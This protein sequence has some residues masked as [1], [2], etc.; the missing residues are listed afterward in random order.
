MLC[1]CL[2]SS[3]HLFRDFG[4]VN[5]YSWF[6]K[7]FNMLDRSGEFSFFRGIHVSIDVRIDISIS[8]RPMQVQAGTSRRLD[9]N[10]ANQA[11]AGDVIMSR[12]LDKLKT[13]YLHSQS[14]NCHETWQD[15]DLSWW[16]PTHNVT[17]PFDHVV[18]LDHVTN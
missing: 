15:G 7:S 1:N 11:G 10:E 4:I 9:W 13:L 5:R 17:R 8:I 3:A 6:W 16:A 18:L 2:C 14:A 12:S